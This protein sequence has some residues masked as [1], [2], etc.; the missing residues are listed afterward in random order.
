MATGIL[1]SIIRLTDM[2]AAPLRRHLA[3]SSSSSNSPKIL[4][5]D[6]VELKN[7][8]TK[9]DRVLNDAEKRE[10]KDESVKLWLRELRGVAYDAE[11]LLDEFEY[12]L[13]RA[14]VEAGARMRDTRK[15]KLDDES[16]PMIVMQPSPLDEPSFRDRM[17]MRMKEIKER[18]DEIAREKEDLHLREEDGTRRVEYRARPVT[19]SYVDQSEVYGRDEACSLLVE[20]LLKS[21]GNEES[22][23]SVIPIVGMPGVGKTTLAQLIYNDSR[24]CG[25]F[26]LRA[27]VCVPEDFHVAK[28]VRVIIESITKSLCSVAEL[29]ELRDCLKD[30]LQDKRFLIVLDNVWNEDQI[31]WESLSSSLCSDVPGCRV[32]VTTRNENVAKIVQANMPVCRLNCLPDDDCWQI[33]RRQAFGGRDDS[34]AVPDLVAIGKMI[35]KKCKGLPLAVKALGGLLRY[36]T[37]QEVWTDVLESDLW[38]IDEAGDEILPALKLS[39]QHLPVHLR[40]CFVYCSVFP[41]NVLFKRNHLVL[42][43]MVQGLIHHQKDQHEQP[44]DTGCEYFEDL[45]CRSFFQ[46][47]A[48]AIGEEDKFMMHD[49]V[50]DLARNLSGE[51]YYTTEFT[52]LGNVSAMVRHASVASYSSEGVMQFHSADKPIAM[53]SLL[54]IHRIAHESGRVGMPYDSNLL[55]LKIPRDVFVNLKCLRAVDLGYTDIEALPDSIGGLKQLRYLSLRNTKIQKLPESVCKLYHLQ[56]LDLD[57]CSSLK[58]L[59][60]GIGNL[61]NLQH[62]DLPTM[63]SSFICIPSGIASLTGLRELAAF[64]VGADSRHCSIGELKHMIHLGGDLYISGLKNVARGWDA[65]EAKME[66]KK[67]IQRLTLDWYIDQSDYKCSHNLNTSVSQSKINSMAMPWTKVED[68]EAVLQSL[69]PHS[70]LVVLEIRHYGGM[71]FPRWLGDPSFSKLVTVKLFMCNHSKV[72]PWLG[73]LPSLKNLHIHGMESIRCIRPEFSATDNF[74]ALEVLSLHC[75]P[76][77]EEWSEVVLP[78]LAELS[79]SKCHKLKNVPQCIAPALKKLDVSE[80]EKLTVL[81]TSASLANL[82]IGGEFQDQI[83]TCI[84]NL[85]Q[86]NSL[87]V[88]YCNSLTCLP[89]HNLPS[90]RSLEINSCSELVSIDCQSSPETVAVAAAAASSSSSVLVNGV[91]LHNLVSLESLKIEECPMLRFLEDD[92]FPSTLK[93]VEITC[94]E[95]LMEWCE[96]VQG[97]SQLSQVPEVLVTDFGVDQ[98]HELI[99]E[100]MGSEEEMDED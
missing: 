74:L 14:R 62:L 89:L 78:Q 21:D 32:M 84:P 85:T 46:K 49:L 38:D 99:K 34:E 53:R 94:C 96:G 50:H 20:L 55:H 73:K 65:K 68:E 4:E 72:L 35:V 77:L 95:M 67:N 48:I 8:L 87:E 69:R 81:P 66:S 97:Q 43:W 5:T 25:H 12:E 58:E 11:D 31:L 82:C 93:S 86:L 42:L 18:L 60:G 63:D 19:S 39:Y 100:E 79:I 91:G 3:A 57:Y 56:I 80:C 1:S 98:I 6:L 51:E 2:L 90:L 41:K 61:L 17:S 92:R 45:I 30:V 7:T 15:R 26:G 83:W 47:S 37:D 71:S 54:L 70:N 16:S 29:D 52:D 36:E 33:F 13:L 76:E 44:E 40:R 64:N 75:L 9:I 23:V 24:V 28:L 22:N 27:W 88:N 10:V 59:P